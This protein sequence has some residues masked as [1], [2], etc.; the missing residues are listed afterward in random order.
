MLHKGS[1]DPMENSSGYVSNTNSMNPAPVKYATVGRSKPGGVKRTTSLIVSQPIVPPYK[2][3]ITLA[4]APRKDVRKQYKNDLSRP[5]SRASRS[6]ANSDPRRPSSRSSRDVPS[7]RLNRH[8]RAGSRRSHSKVRRPES[9]TSSK[10]LILRRR[11]SGRR[12]AAGAKRSA[13]IRS[14]RS[15]EQRN[16]RPSSRTSQNS[17]RSGAKR[18]PA[19]NKSSIFASWKPRLTLRRSKSL[20]VKPDQ[21]QK[22][23]IRFGDEQ[24]PEVIMMKGVETRSRSYSASQPRSET[25]VK[26][27]SSVNNAPS[28]RVSQTLTRPS[29]RTSPPSRSDRAASAEVSRRL[30]PVGESAQE[31]ETPRS[32]RARRYQKHEVVRGRTSSLSPGKQRAPS[33]MSSSPPP[34]APVWRDDSED[35]LSDT[36]TNRSKGSTVRSNRR[37]ELYSARQQRSNRSRTQEPP[38]E[39]RRSAEKSSVLSFLRRTFSIK[40]KEK[41]AKPAAIVKKR[42]R[43][44]SSSL[45]SL[46]RPV[47]HSKMKTAKSHEL[48]NVPDE[49]YLDEKDRY[50]SLPRHKAKNHSSGT[51][52]SRRL[53]SLGWA[54]TGG[55]SRPERSRSFKDEKTYEYHANNAAPSH[56]SGDT[57]VRNNERVLPRPAAPP[58]ATNETSHGQL[59]DDELPIRPIL[60]ERRALSQPSLYHP[61]AVEPSDEPFSHYANL[62]FQLPPR[63]RSSPNLLAD[64]EATAQRATSQ[65]S[66]RARRSA[67]PDSS[68]SSSTIHASDRQREKRAA[69]GKRPPGKSIL[70]QQKSDE[71]KNVNVTKDE[72]L[73]RKQ[74][75]SVFQGIAHNIKNV[76]KVSNLSVGKTHAQKWSGVIIT[77]RQGTGF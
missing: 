16:G 28:K 58:K 40:P 26:S 21:V 68:R 10:A 25:Y 74:K 45:S 64:A 57:A 19:R 24:Q 66:L 8:H 29:K 47:R 44:S 27:H 63:R 48:L 52:L 4:P 11:D 38:S 53:S 59:F 55:R 17:H 50:R 9:R 60:Q 67:T 1:P 30:A 31:D 41:P 42:E 76:F 12:T 39:P 2:S 6:S 71:V 34:R 49:E 43:A 56:D 75:S 37:S 33:E 69:G 23:E 15:D 46:E 32:P 72:A 5:S 13:S 70:K 62:P 20:Q 77:K 18:E 7:E 61:P 54:A 22:R 3:T 65:P 14:G 73:P 36:L 35:S 51:T